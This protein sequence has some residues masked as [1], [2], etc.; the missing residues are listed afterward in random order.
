MATALPEIEK[1]FKKFDPITP[2]NYQF[3]DEDYARNFRGEERIGKLASFFTV[4]ALFIS[5]M[6]M[7]GMVSNVLERRTKEIGIRKVLG[8]SILSLWRILTSE[9]VLLIFLSGL[10]ALP[11]AYYF[12]S[13]WLENYEYRVD[14]SPWVLILGLMSAILIT[15]FTISFQ[16]IRS[17]RSN[18]VLAL[19]SE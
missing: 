4:L 18:P 8:A 9:F 2:F 16:A 11:I 7:V 15:L 3:I 10:I 19:R 17:A 5:C 13:G 1:V 6:G 12:M 14:I